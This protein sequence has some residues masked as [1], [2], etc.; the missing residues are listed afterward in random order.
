MDSQDQRK[1]LEGIC[2]IALTVD[3]KVQFV[4]IVEGSGKL[5]VGKY[6]QN[7]EKVENRDYSCLIKSSLFYSRFIIPALN[8]CKKSGKDS[9]EL[10]QLDNLKLAIMPLLTEAD[11]YLCI[12]L[13]PS[14]SYKE[15]ISKVIETV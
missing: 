9:I 3:E 1:I 5:L 12:Y 6:R 15:I 2:Y 8:S 13:H 11:R 14:A 7:I 10:I 4:G